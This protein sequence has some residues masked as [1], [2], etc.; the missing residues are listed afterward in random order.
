[1]GPL[2]I[3]IQ[4][5]TRYRFGGYTSKSWTKPSSSNWPGDE[6]A[7]AFSIN[8]KRKFEIKIPNEAVGH[9]SDRGPVF[10][11]GHCFDISSGCLNN[12]DSYHYNS[13][14]YDGTNQIILTEQK[15]FKVSD[16]EVFQIKFQ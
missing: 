7:F 15:N 12:F 2:L 4:T 13:N 14:S 6:L 10:G 16:Y 11:Y 1:M 8:L 5:T 3:I 9:Y